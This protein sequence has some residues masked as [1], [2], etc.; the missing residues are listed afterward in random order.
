MYNLSSGSRLGTLPLEVGTVSG[1]SG[2]KEHTEV[3]VNSMYNL[4]DGSRLGTLPL[5]VGTVSGY[6]GK[7]EHTEVCI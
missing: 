5:E 3:C 2:K 6:S 4:S 1:Y 7:K